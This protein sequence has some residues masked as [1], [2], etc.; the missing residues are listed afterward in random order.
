MH[1]LVYDREIW[2]RK[3]VWQTGWHLMFAQSYFVFVFVFCIFAEFFWSTQKG[4][5]EEK[6]HNKRFSKSDSM[7]KIFIVLH[8]KFW[9]E[10]LI[11]KVTPTYTNATSYSNNSFY[12]LIGLLYVL[13]LWEM[14]DVLNATSKKRR[15]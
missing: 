8:V 10:M 4:P 14:Y 12:F 11:Q 13:W 7:V 2:T 1:Q 15:N 5:V 9:W 3:I 6:F